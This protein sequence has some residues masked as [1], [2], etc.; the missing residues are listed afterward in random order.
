MRM[1][2]HLLHETISLSRLEAGF[3]YMKLYYWAAW[4]QDSVTWK[5]IT[6]PL[7]S[8][9][10]FYYFPSLWCWWIYM[11]IFAELSYFQQMHIEPSSRARKL[12][13]CCRIGGERAGRVGC[14]TH[15]ENTSGSVGGHG[16]DSALAR[17]TPGSQHPGSC[18]CVWRWGLYRG[19]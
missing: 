4:K 19:G 1:H 16:R 15:M 18:D 11:W 5:Y 14:L 9:I 12:S 10:L 7:G 2:D 8:R 6:E 17:I 3:C 13:K